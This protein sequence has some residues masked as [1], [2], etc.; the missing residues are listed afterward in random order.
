MDKVDKIDNAKKLYDTF[1]KTKRPI[2][3]IIQYQKKKDIE[4]KIKILQ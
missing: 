3:A 4:L 1:T 2:S